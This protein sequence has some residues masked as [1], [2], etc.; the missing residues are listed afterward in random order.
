MET[1]SGAKTY[2]YEVYKNL[3]LKGHPMY[4]YL[5]IGSGLSNAVFVHEVVK[6][7]KTCLV[8]ERR[9]TSAVLTGKRHIQELSSINILNSEHS[10]EL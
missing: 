4:D 7:G 2:I 9:I 6:S 1:N 3:E 10:Q 8:L 5:L